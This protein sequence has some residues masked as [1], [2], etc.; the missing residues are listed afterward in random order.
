VVAQ[1]AFG[2]LKSSIQM[3]TPPHTPVPFTKVLED[4]YIPKAEAIVAAV[5]RTM[6]G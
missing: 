1:D 3:V 6:K 4:A 5:N 2:A